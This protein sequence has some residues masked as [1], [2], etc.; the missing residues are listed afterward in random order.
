MP[1]NKRNKEKNNTTLTINEMQKLF[2][3]VAKYADDPSLVT[4]ILMRD[5]TK[6]EKVIETTV[7]KFKI[8]RN[9]RTHIV[10][11]KGT[12]NEE[13]LRVTPLF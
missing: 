11:D 4:L 5:H 9:G 10:I 7:G 12:K 1:I 3:K 2:N 6:G 8:R 13:W